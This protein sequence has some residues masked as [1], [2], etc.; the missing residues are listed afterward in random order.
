MSRFPQ[1]EREN[2]TNGSPATSPARSRTLQSDPPAR[3]RRHHRVAGSAGGHSWALGSGHIVALPNHREMSSCF[4]GSSTP[5]FTSAL[6]LLVPPDRCWTQRSSPRATSDT[7]GQPRAAS[8]SCRHPI[9]G[10][11]PKNLG[12]G[13]S[14][15]TTPCVKGGTP[16]RGAE[17]TTVSPGVENGTEVGAENG[18][19]FRGFGGR[20]AGFRERTGLSWWRLVESGWSR[21]SGTWRGHP[22]QRQ[23]GDTPAAAL[24]CQAAC[25]AGMTRAATT[26]VRRSAMSAPVRGFGGRRPRPSA[27]PAAARKAGGSKGGAAYP[28][29]TPMFSIGSAGSRALLVMWGASAEAPNGDASPATRV[30]SLSR[31]SLQ[32][33]ISSASIRRQGEVPDDLVLILGGYFPE[34]REELQDRRLRDP[35]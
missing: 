35:C 18:K 32:M 6:Q 15:R 14:H 30:S 20:S 4:L 25:S 33:R 10:G 1:E 13:H 11:R 22:R 16:G 26:T 31:D 8:I 9:R 2:T 21:R 12:N 27:A 17:T 24:S 23:D 29:Q 34:V 19:L 7:A 28:R 5:R 3:R